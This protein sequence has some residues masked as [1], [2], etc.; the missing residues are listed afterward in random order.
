MTQPESEFLL[1]LDPESTSL[2]TQTFASLTDTYDVPLFTDQ[3][4]ALRTELAQNQAAQERLLMHQIFNGQIME[5]DAEQALTA[6]LFTSIGSET[7][8]SSSSVSKA[9]TLENTPLI[10]GVGILFLCILLFIEIKN[11]QKRK[12]KNE[13]ET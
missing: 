13:T 10:C 1:E 12:R 3:L 7:M 6:H 5:S 9:N 11:L 8:L 4:E 2:R